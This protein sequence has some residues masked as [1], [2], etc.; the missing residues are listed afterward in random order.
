MG[1]DGAPEGPDLTKGIAEGELPEGGLLA[2][3]ANGEAVLLARVEG[4]V[5]AVGATCPH[6]GGPLAEG[7]IVGDTIRCPWHHACF[8]LKTGEALRAPALDGLPVWRVA[9]RDGRVVVG[10]R[11]TDPVPKRMPAAAPESVLILGG[12]AAGHAAAEQLRREGYA[13]PVTVID[14][15]Q[16]EPFDKPNLSKDYLAGKA[17]EEW[18][19]LRPLEFFAEQDIQRLT[20]RRAVSIDLDGRE[21]ALDDGTVVGFDRLL[22]ATGARPVTLP[23]AVDPGGR[24]RYLRTF[25]DSRAIIAAAKQARGAVVIGA[26]FIGLEVAASLRAREL[27]VHV[28]APET[29]PLAQILGDDLGRFVRSIHEEHGVQFHLERTVQDVGSGAVMLSDGAAI[30][31][32]LV[33]AGIGV[34]PEDRLAAEAGLAVDDGILVNERLETGTPGVYAAGDV[35]RFPDARTG[36][37]VRIEHWVVAERMGQCAARNM[38]GAE[39]RFGDAPFFWSQHYD[40]VIAYVGHADQWDRAELDGEP[41]SMDCAVRFLREGNL[42]AVATI[43]RDR[44]SLEAEAEMERPA[45][46]G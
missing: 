44:E 12:G 24:V 22:I 13:G 38:L 3:Q 42:R 7:L 39:E 43:F 8:S 6:Y 37:P 10:E 30:E 40:A 4:R 14:A 11:V 46:A 17:Q 31:A 19:P 45:A 16:D 41:A 21:V 23:R 27:P 36:T 18:I 28:V 35:A 20:G 26:S 32:D 1:G 9:Q 33:V 15:D 2:G 25:A 34:R 29:L 5:H